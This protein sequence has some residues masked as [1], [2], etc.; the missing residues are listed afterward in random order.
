MISRT[1]A[2]SS[3]SATVR[4]AAVERRRDEPEIES[5]PWLELLGTLEEPVKGVQDVVISMHP[6]FAIGSPVTI[7]V[8]HPRPS[9]GLYRPSPSGSSP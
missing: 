5:Q 3:F 2:V 1:V 9:A 8:S 4:T 7:F 6:S